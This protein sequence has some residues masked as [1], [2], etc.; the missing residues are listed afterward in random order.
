MRKHM[1]SVGTLV[2]LLALACAAL[3]SSGARQ[4]VFTTV[5]DSYSDLCLI[6]SS[7]TGYEKLTTTSGI[8]EGDPDWSPD[9]TKIVFVRHE[10]ANYGLYIMSMPDRT[11]RRVW[12]RASDIAL[13][14]AFQESLRMWGP[15]WSP[16]GKRIAFLAA[17]GYFDDDT[18]NWPWGGYCDHEGVIFVVN[19][20][21]TNL[22]R[23][24]FPETF[25]DDCKSVD[26]SPDGTKLVF[27]RTV[28]VNSQ[29]PDH[30]RHP[31]LYVMN[32]DGSGVA[33]LTYGDTMCY[34]PRWSPD[35]SRIIFS[36]ASKAS[37]SI[38]WEIWSVNPDGSYLTQ[39]TFDKERYTALAWSMDSQKIV[40]ADNGTGPGALY[41]MQADGSNRRMLVEDGNDPS[42][43]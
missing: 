29:I 24:S 18:Y 2:A 26:W 21:G 34:G 30:W 23:L 38:E 17:P 20:D 16:D 33:R 3:S 12:I 13:E 1:I 11:V 37:G 9:G 35:G 15:T 7:G 31:E 28:Y 42:W 41:I 40:F 39:L 5:I 6:S 43:W 32:S 19:E 22:Q 25:N 14:R 10:T 27:S 8:S 36:R 4:I